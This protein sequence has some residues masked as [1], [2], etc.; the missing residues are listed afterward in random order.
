MHG[1]G[2]VI[3]QLQL[4][5]GTANTFMV[6]N[7]RLATD[8]GHNLLS[9]IL[10]AKKGIKLFLRKTGQPYEIF[11]EDEVVGLADMIDNQYVTRLAKPLISKVNVVKNL[12]TEIWHFRLSHL[13]YGAIQILASVALDMEFQGSI[14]LEIYGGCMVGRQQRKPSQESPSRQVTEFL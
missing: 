5:D 14:P 2:E 13:S 4:L 6:T 11:F 8:L 3:L 9:T 12:T 1:Y 7:V 10:L